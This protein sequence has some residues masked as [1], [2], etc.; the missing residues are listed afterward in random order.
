MP[1]GEGMSNKDYSSLTR[2]LEPILLVSLLIFRDLLL[3]HKMA[4]VAPKSCLHRTALKAGRK[5]AGD[6]PFYYGGEIS[7]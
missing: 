2:S 7:Q 1:N 3:D 6:F 4:A 5:G